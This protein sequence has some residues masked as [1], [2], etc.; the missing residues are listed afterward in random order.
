[1]AHYENTK[2]RMVAISA[3]KDIIESTCQ[4]FLVKEKKIRPHGCSILVKYDSKHYCLSNSHVLNRIKFPEVF[5]L[6]KDFNPLLLEGSILFSESIT[7]EKFTNDTY[8][9][10]IMELEIGIVNNL[11]TNGHKFLSLEKAEISVSLLRE[12]VTMIAAFPANKT[13]FNFKKKKLKFNPLIIRT[14]PSVKDYSNLGFPKDVHHCVE[15]PR[16]SFLEMST[17]NRIIAP[18]PHGISGSGLWILAGTSALDYKPYLIGILSE[19]HENK[20][21][22]FAT[23]IDIYI[24]VM[25]QV[26]DIKIQYSGMKVNLTFIQ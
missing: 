24:S 1:M 7:D 15:Y 12:S 4:L 22:V 14:K 16:K 13:K 21:L 10:A 2:E 18:K 9:I 6:D 19:Y 26:F 11:T 8:D 20:S 3:A 17:G 5:F 25:Q 23:K